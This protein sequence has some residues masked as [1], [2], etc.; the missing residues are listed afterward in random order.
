[1]TR[2]RLIFLALLYLVLL[3]LLYRYNISPTYAYAGFTYTDLPVTAWLAAIL[4]TS[5]PP[6][7][8]P[9]RLDRPSA[10]TSWV[11]YICVVV[12]V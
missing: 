12:P 1:M 5:L 9:L 7:Y 10:I 4:V 6:C 11:L 8:L 2:L 3:V